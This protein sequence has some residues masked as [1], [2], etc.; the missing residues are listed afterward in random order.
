MTDALR[1]RMAGVPVWAEARQEK[2]GEEDKNR[3]AIRPLCCGGLRKNA[4][5]GNGRATCYNVAWARTLRVSA[6]SR[7]ICRVRGLRGF[8]ALL[9]A[10]AGHELQAHGLAV[11]IFR[12]VQQKTFNA[13]LAAA[14]SGLSAHIGHGLIS[15]SAH[16]HPCGVHALGRQQRLRR[17]EIRR[18]K[19]Q[20]AA[21]SLAVHHRARKTVKTAQETAARQ[22]SPWADQIPRRVELTTASSTMTG[23]TC[24][25][26]KPQRAPRARSTSACPLRSRP[27][28]KS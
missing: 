22:T 11:E 9:A 15:A 3:N 27:R 24:S 10:Q 21:A 14:E 16:A 12:G 1:C 18:G 6:T 13:Q 25:T 17:H 7:V 8:K 4:V 26:P 20:S 19:T 2:S 5:C 23:G 28:E